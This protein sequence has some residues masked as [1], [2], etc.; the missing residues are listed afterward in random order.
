MSMT[1]SLGPDDVVQNGG[2]DLIKSG[3]TS[4]VKIYVKYDAGSLATSRVSNAQRSLRG[5]HHGPLT[6]YIIFWVERAP[7]MLGTF[8]PPPTSM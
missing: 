4:S 6:R 3:D 7:R 2:Q 1:N 8:S 5:F